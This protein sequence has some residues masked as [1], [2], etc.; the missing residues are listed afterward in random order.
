MDGLCVVTYITRNRRSERQRGDHLPL[1]TAYKG[2]RSDATGGKPLQPGPGRTEASG[3]SFPRAV[4]PV[5]AWRGTATV[6]ANAVGALYGNRRRLADC[7]GQC[8]AT[9]AIQRPGRH[10]V[11]AGSAPLLTSSI[12]ESSGRR[13]SQRSFHSW[14]VG[15]IQC[16]EETDQIAAAQKVDTVKLVHM[17]ASLRWRKGWLHRRHESSAR[18]VGRREGNGREADRRLRILDELPVAAFNP[19]PARIVT[20]RHK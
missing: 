4:E 3:R 7:R 10:E 5:G 1:F 18:G 17:G 12:G 13:N 15:Y 9:V 11:C 14:T 2:F 19:W 8:T 20:V 6:A 16:G